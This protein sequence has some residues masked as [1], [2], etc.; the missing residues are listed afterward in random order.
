MVQQERMFLS[1]SPDD[2]IIAMFEADT[3]SDN[4]GHVQ[5]TL[6]DGRSSIELYFGNQNIIKGRT[7]IARLRHMLDRVESELN[8]LEAQGS[9]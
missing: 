4:Y 1:D 3:Q 9:S 8:S 7:T 6:M 5:L 2:P